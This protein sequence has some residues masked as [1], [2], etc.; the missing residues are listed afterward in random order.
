M[1][2][3]DSICVLGLDGELF[4]ELFQLLSKFIDGDDFNIFFIDVLLSESLF[5]D[6]GAHVLNG[7]K[8]L[9]HFKGQVLINNC[10]PV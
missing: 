1:A 10:L 6:H 5:H 3:G 7:L 2:L 4:E 8:F 9:S